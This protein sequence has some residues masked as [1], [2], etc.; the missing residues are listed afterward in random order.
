MGS[1]R[2]PGK[3]MLELQGKTMIEFLL[4]RLSQS[5]SLTQI[6]IATSGDPA[7]DALEKHVNQLGY[8]VFRGSENDVLDRFFLAAQSLGA[9]IVVRVTGDCP[10]IDGE[11]VDRVV[12]SFLERNVDYASNLEPPTFPDGLDVEVFSMAALKV[13][14]Q[15][16][17]TDFD[18]E[19]VTPYL[20]REPQF[21]RANVVHT[22]DCSGERWT[23]DDPE[24]LKV[25]H[26]IARHFYPRSD[27]TLRE[28][29]ELRKEKPQIFMA[30]Q[31]TK[32]NE[33]AS[34]G[35]GQ[36]LWKRAK[37]V[38]PGGNM[39]LSKRAEMFLPEK[40]PAYFSK[41]K[42]CQVWDL[43]GNEYTDA[44]IMGIG[45]NI[46][47]YGHPAVDEAVRQVVSEGNMATFNCP[48]EVLL[49]ERLVELHPWAEMVRFARTGGEAN[50]ISIRIARAAAG[51]S[52]VAFCGYHG[53]HDWYLA[54]NLGSEQNLDGHLLEGLSPN[55]VPRGLKDS[56]LPFNFNDFEALEDLVRCHD[57]GVIKMEVQR[58]SPPEPGFL[59]KRTGARLGERHRLNF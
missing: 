35:K 13:A 34:M 28:I 45:T 46:L 6:A 40:W 3:V 29:L 59:E 57:V 17:S 30:N 21:T 53:W 5:K 58:S 41:A 16:A 18:R 23:V 39:L 1:T 4:N 20:R 52:Q 51:K 50:A 47:G 11:V 48:E 22:E 43:D 12:S 33:G 24:D 32:R 8:E 42:G 31:N 7:N 26:E 25:V 27:F 44:S 49:A 9:E 15:E 55:G 56:V 37:R 38:I 10:L 36:K 19:H 54:A 14:W 2:L